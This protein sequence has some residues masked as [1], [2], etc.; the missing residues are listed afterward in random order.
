MKYNDN[1]KYKKPEID[2]SYI[3]NRREKRERERK[4]NNFISI[5]PNKIWFKSLDFYTKCKAYDEFQNQKRL[6][7]LFWNLDLVWKNLEEKY[8]GD[9][10]IIRD[11]KINEIL[12]II[13]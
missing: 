8:P 13:I 11:L 1:W 9:K 12:D 10:S 4:I 2:P 3:S 6:Y 7:E 5:V